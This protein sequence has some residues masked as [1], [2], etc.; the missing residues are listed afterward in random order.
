MSEKKLKIK[1]SPNGE[2][3]MYTE[4]V[5]GKECEQY[6][7]ILENLI[8]VKITQKEYTQEY[9]EQEQSEIIITDN[10]N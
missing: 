8:D 4:G 6:I 1:I 10:N 9:Y 7:R 2:I 3:K 5:K